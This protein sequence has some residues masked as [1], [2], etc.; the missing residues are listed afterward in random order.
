VAKETT[1]A[2]ITKLSVLN[3][4]TVSLLKS[5]EMPQVEVGIEAN[6]ASACKTYTLVNRLLVRFPTKIS[7]V[8]TICNHHPT[9]AKYLSL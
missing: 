9:R 4:K 2:L 8:S 5:D 1:E 6:L 3:F 7:D